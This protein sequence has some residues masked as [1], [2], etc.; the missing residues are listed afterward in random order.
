M[1]SRIHFSKNSECF[2]HNSHHNRREMIKMKVKDTEINYILT[3][4]LI[5]LRD[6][7]NVTNRCSS[8]RRIATMFAMTFN[9][10][11]VTLDRFRKLHL[12]NES[13][14]A[15]RVLQIKNLLKEDI[16]LAAETHPQRAHSIRSSVREDWQKSESEHR[17]CR[18]SS[19]RIGGVNG[20]KMADGRSESYP[21][22]KTFRMKYAW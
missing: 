3:S 11:S 12:M 1:Q 7:R 17:Y 10:H 9:C 20:I 4:V 15:C 6:Q 18:N 14:E 5:S 13:A 19:R 2:R 21:R 16:W 8:C 22:G